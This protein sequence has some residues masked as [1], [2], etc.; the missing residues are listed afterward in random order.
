MET[1]ILILLLIVGIAIGFAISLYWSNRF[2]PFRWH[3]QTSD[4]AGE[5]RLRHPSSLPESKNLTEDL[6]S[7]NKLLIQAL[8]S[9][10]QGI[11]I[12]SIEGK[13]LIRNKVAS[14]IF[15]GRHQNALAARAFDELLTLAK[16]GTMTERSLE[17][18]GP[19]KRSY[20]IRTDSLISDGTT[21]GVIAILEDISDK[22]HLDEV[23]RDFVSNVSHELKTPIGAMGLLAETLSSEN[24]LEI[25]K[26]L[27][28]RIQNEAFRLGRIIDDLLDLSR[29]ESD[30]IPAPEPV[31]IEK[32]VTEV[33]NR[34][35]SSAEVRHVTIEQS[36][37]D[38]PCYVIGDRREL[39]SAVYNLL[40]NAV[41][42]SESGSKVLVELKTDGQTV[43][44]AVKDQ[45]IGIP[46]RDLERIFERFYRVDQA[47]S[48]AT[49]GTGLGLSIVRHVANNHNGNVFVESREGSG[50]VF[51][52][53]LP[54][55][56]GD[57]E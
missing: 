24:D 33:V 29:I 32:M 50:S 11:T 57:Q 26:R 5:D 35:G 42:Y 46:S 44:I 23:R 14:L 53:R 28:V 6:L 19:P 51:T 4:T 45:G 55:A 15:E 49:G 37:A 21:I 1:F 25:A 10:P 7:H 47:R 13:V 22:R 31:E 43:D 30:D 40:D 3:E 8:D 20:T 48:R 54:L 41:K 12:C 56:E 52:L 39:M 34:I 2:H 27:S 16:A 9:I 18:Y 17:I 36:P 38:S